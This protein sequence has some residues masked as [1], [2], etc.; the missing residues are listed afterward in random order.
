MKINYVNREHVHALIDLPTSKCVEDV[1]Q[2][3]K[4][5]SSHWINQVRMVPG[6]FAWGRGYGAFSVAQS[7]VGEVCRYIANQEKHHKRKT[8]AEE[9]ALFVQRYQLTWREDRG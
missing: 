2:L 4:G 7:G 5:G 9:F 1:M 3:F 6:K 8:W